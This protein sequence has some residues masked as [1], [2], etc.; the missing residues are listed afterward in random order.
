MPGGDGTTKSSTSSSR[1][2]VR[3]TLS[4][5]SSAVNRNKTF[6]KYAKVIFVCFLIFSAKKPVFFGTKRTLIWSSLFQYY[7]IDSISSHCWKM[8]ILAWRWQKSTF[9]A[10][11]YPSPAWL[12]AWRGISS[13]CCQFK[14]TNQMR[15]RAN[16]GRGWLQS[17]RL[18]RY[19]VKTVADCKF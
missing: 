13:S 8:R 16:Q 3:R 17:T 11:I 2:G 9:H 6:I 4:R 7:W 19:V 5:N 10:T 15:Q 1:T 14:S 18:Q 12:G